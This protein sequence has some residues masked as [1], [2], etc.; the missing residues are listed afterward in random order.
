MIDKEEVQHFLNQ[1]HSKMKVYGIIYRDDRG[2]NRQTLQALEI[3]PMYRRVVIESLTV[4]DYVQ[5]PLIDELNRFGEMS[6]L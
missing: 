6:K 4:E 1:F 2:K 3:V 5:G